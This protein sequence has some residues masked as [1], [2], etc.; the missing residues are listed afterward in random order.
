MIE[1]NEYAPMQGPRTHLRCKEK[2]GVF[3]PG[4]TAQERARRKRT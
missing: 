2:Y 4:K 1:R 3:R